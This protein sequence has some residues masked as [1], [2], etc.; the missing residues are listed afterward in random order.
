MENSRTFWIFVFIGF[1]LTIIYYLQNNVKL[2]SSLK[3]KIDTPSGIIENFADS[4]NTSNTIL[5]IP[6]QANIGMYINAFLDIN[7]NSS[8]YLI[9]GWLDTYNPNTIEFK[10]TNGV[11]PTS[12][13]ETGFPTKTI[14]L[15]G[16]SSENIADKNKILK[17]FTLAFYMQINNNLK[18]TLDSNDE[19]IDIELLQIYM[20]TPYYVIFYITPDLKVLTNVNINALVGNSVYTW[21]IA[22]SSIVT[23]NMFSFV[24]DTSI[25]ANTPIITLYINTANINITSPPKINTPTTL[26]VQNLTLGVSQMVINKGGYLDANLWAFVYYN[27]I[28]SSTDITELY[29]YFNQQKSGYANLQAL[30]AQQAEQNAKDANSTSNI[31]SDLATCHKINAELK[32]K[33]TSNV[34]KT[35]PK[36]NWNINAG[37]ASY[38]KLS[39]S[40][41]KNCSLL[42]VK[43]FGQSNTD[44]YNQTSGAPQK[45]LPNNL[46]IQ[47]PLS[48]TNNSTS[49]KTKTPKND[50]IVSS[51]SKSS[52][53]SRSITE[54]ILNFFNLN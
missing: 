22:L 53:G 24:I 3:K 49:K 42:D 35:P 15:L 33:C 51:T 37:A 40:S 27:S 45:Y 25:N 10:Y 31:T 21:N 28:L 46:K 50:D 19:P 47:Y 16:P 30:L 7:G 12:L 39:D 6:Q 29:N 52:S 54:S 1:L 44:V 8:T 13:T 20:Q 14:G 18:F 2:V 23:G 11:P 34:V 48:S 17:S 32:D 9:S 36:P 43:K 41:F 38:S 4:T 5:T 26:Y